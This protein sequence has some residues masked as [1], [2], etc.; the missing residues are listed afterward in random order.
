MAK[1]KASF[2][3]GL[4]VITVLGLIA[5]IVLFKSIVIIKPGFAGVVYNMN[6]G[7]TNSSLSQGVH[8]VWPWQSVTS[9]PVSRETVFLTADTKEGSDNDE[10]FP[11]A[12]SDGQPVRIGVSYT[13]HFDP[14]H[15]GDVFNFF[16]GAPTSTIEGGFIR[17]RLKPDVSAASCQYSISDIYGAKRNVVAMAAMEALSKDLAKNY[18]V[19]DDF[20][21]TDVIPDANTLTAINEKVRATQ[22]LQKAMITKQQQEISAQTLVI[23]AQG[24]ADAK[25]VAAQGEAKANAA[26]QKSI[27]PELVRYKQIEVMGKQA[28]A[29]KNWNVNTYI[30]GSGSGTLLNIPTETTKK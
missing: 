8:G 12:S 5:L 24:E 16:K 26:L 9:Y 15:L 22:E 23:K 18:I 3:K 10:S 25:Y 28:E 19:I 30:Q 11:I 2:I 29:Q 1:R 4:I 27:T 7:V 17:S 21:I 6:G 20:G 13:Y 14:H